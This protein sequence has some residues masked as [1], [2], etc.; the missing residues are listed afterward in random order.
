VRPYNFGAS[1]SILAKLFQTTCREAGV[2]MWVQL[3]CPPPKIWECKKRPNFGAIS[4]NFR[5]WS[6]FSSI[7]ALIANVSGTDRHFESRKKLDHLNWL[8][9]RTCGVG[10]PHIGFCPRLVLSVLIVNYELLEV[11]LYKTRMWLKIGLYYRYNF[12]LG[13]NFSKMET[14]WLLLLRN[15]VLYAY[16]GKFK[17]QMVTLLKP[18]RKY[19]WCHTLA[20]W[21]RSSY[22]WRWGD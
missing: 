11:S 9:T 10:R 2:L 16:Y 17:F 3:E 4:D 12:C 19:T 22:H 15:E 5:L 21:S 18:G 8:S 6:W 20:L 13:N 1:G 7:F 14:W